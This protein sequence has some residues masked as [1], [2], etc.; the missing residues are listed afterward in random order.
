MRVLRLEFTGSGRQFHC[1]RDGAR[2]RQVRDSASLRDC[3][4]DATS[5]AA[6]CVPGVGS[7]DAASG[8]ASRFYAS[9]RFWGLNFSSPDTLWA[10]PDAERK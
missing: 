9:R 7:M 8:G 5:G 4:P 6:A 1:A 3:L 2:F 10:S